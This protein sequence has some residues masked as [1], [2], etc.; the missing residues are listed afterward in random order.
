MNILT[1]RLESLCVCSVPSCSVPREISSNTCMALMD[2]VKNMYVSVV[3]SLP[4]N[5]AS[6]NTR[7]N[8]A[9][10][11]VRNEAVL[12]AWYKLKDTRI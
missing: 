8:V 7:A 5:K 10:I 3:L 12:V 4:G 6:I 1:E 2:M 9:S 11:R